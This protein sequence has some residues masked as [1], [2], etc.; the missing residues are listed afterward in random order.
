MTDT[1]TKDPSDSKTQRDIEEKVVNKIALREN[2][3]FSKATT[4]NNI[5]YEFDFYNEERKI[6]GEVYAGI[7]KLSSGAKRKVITDCFKLVAAEI[8]LGV[9]CDKRIVFIDEKIK[10]YFEGKSWIANA[11]KQFEIKL[12]IEN[13]EEVD[14]LALRKAKASQQNGNIYKKKEN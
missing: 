14:M 10:K 3:T 12:Y 2:C 13:I 1:E 7:D 9:K 5:K 4:I 8:N 11:I 6:I